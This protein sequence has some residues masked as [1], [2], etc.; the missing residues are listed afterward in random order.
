MLENHQK[1][2]VY[3][4]KELIKDCW[5][6]LKGYRFKFIVY[7]L[8]I[9]L[10]NLMPFVI[11]YFL[12]SIVDFFVNYSK[13]DSLNQFYILVL[14][15]AS[16]GAFQAWSRFFVKW[17]LYFIAGELRMKARVMAMIKLADLELKW[18][19]KEETGSKIQKITSGGDNIFASFKF[20][21]DSGIP[22][23]AGLIGGLIALTFLNINYVIF[24][25]I[26]ITLHISAEYYFNKKISYWQDQMNKIKERVSG[27]FHESASNILTVKTLG[28]KSTL[29][30]SV[31]NYEK[32][33]F[34]TS[35]HNRAANQNKFRTIKIF[36][37]VIYALFIFLLGR[38]TLAGLISVGSIIIFLGYFERIRGALDSITNNLSDFIEIKSGVGR[39]MILL[40]KKTIEKESYPYQD[41]P[42][43]WKNIE[44]KDIS[45]KYK[46]KWIFKD[47]NLDIKNGEKLGIVGKSGSGKSTIAKLLLGLY[48]PQ[49]GIITIGGLD[50][51]KAK[52]SSLT[53]NISIILQDSE[54]FNLPIKE[55]IAIAAGKEIT[56][57]SFAKAIE[58]SDLEEF[59][60]KLPQKENSIIGE[61]GYRVS[62]GERQ[63]IGIARAV[64]KNSDIL[65]MDEATS[66]LDSKTESMI[67]KNMKSLLQDKTVLTI[68]HRLSTLR[69]M[70]RI[71]FIDEGKV[72][73]IGSFEALIRKKGKFY[74]LWNKQKAL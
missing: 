37:A 67:Q 27:K 34:E 63:R 54:M 60:S 70:D 31:E 10:S 30:N 20:Y 71:I 23:L 40:D 68:A 56:P 4:T 15:I 52:N 62:G 17:R 66:H 51:N 12:G 73:E 16:A 14:G 33:Y 35:L 24:S 36:S 21:V 28:I 3:T 11:A 43:N 18:H 6:L 29:K 38:D 5:F 22:I 49:K 50:V 44:F 32:E 26:F 2:K 19:E 65:I 58:V 53:K 9:I 47:F 57:I 55:N 61:K 64:Y 7:S 39:I 41:I 8:L 25:I 59:I 74:E 45:F 46:K 13:G 72:V 69:E 42:K 1:N 48:K